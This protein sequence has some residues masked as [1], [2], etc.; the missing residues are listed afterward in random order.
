[1]AEAYGEMDDF[2]Y[3]SYT[4]HGCIKREYQKYPDDTYFA[5]RHELKP[6]EN[7]E[8]EI[9]VSEELFEIAKNENPFY[10]EDEDSLRYIDDNDTLILNCNG[11][12]LT[13]LVKEIDRS[14]KEYQFKRHNLIK[15]KYKIEA[16]YFGNHQ[17]KILQPVVVQ[18]EV[19]TNFGRENQKREV[20][21]LQLDDVKQ[22][23]FIGEIEFN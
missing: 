2:S 14:K 23:F 6:I 9:S 18:A 13:F 17:Q 10:L 22:T 8:F 12:S 20:L 5:S 7:E 3:S 19:Y 1:M 15:G 4:F 11:K 21:T 16:N